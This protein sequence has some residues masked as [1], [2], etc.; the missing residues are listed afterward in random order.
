MQRILQLLSGFRKP[1]RFLQNIRQNT[2]LQNL[3]LLVLENGTMK[4]DT[5]TEQFSEVVFALDTPE[6]SGATPVVRQTERIPG[7]SVHIP[8]ANFRTAIA[9]ALG[10]KPQC[11]RFTAE[12]MAELHTS[13]MLRG[14]IS[15]I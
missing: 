2:S 11:P 12:D 9:S 6:A 1:R 10:K 14:L 4:R 5:W 15:G 7:A 8:D 13:L 3:G